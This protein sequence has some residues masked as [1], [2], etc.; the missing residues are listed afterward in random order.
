VNC[1]T[2]RD[3]GIEGGCEECGLTPSQV[4][5]AA[6]LPLEV[7]EENR[8]PS[9]YKGIDWSGTVLREDHKNLI[10]DVKFEEY[11]S[12]CEKLMRD[13]FD[14]GRAP[15]FSLILV[16][17]RGYGKRTFAYT[18]IKNILKAGGSTIP[19][20]D[21]QE[22]KLLMN[23]GLEKKSENVYEA[24][25]CTYKDFLNADFVICSVVKSYLYQGAY[26]VIE[27]ACDIRSRRDKGIFF[28]SAFNLNDMSNF[29]YRKTF[30]E[31]FDK[32]SGVDRQRRPAVIQYGL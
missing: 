7:Y 2:C 4:I 24:L 9:Y 1:Y 16:A 11:V 28:T 32:R 6:S 30:M 8:I 25:G 14:V 26:E 10:G 3:E 22:L 5:T 23:V 15:R 31:N 19:L 21:T 20:L 12:K 13:F 29:D 27:Q 17:P 18:A